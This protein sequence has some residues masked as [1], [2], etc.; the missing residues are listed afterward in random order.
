MKVPQ[1]KSGTMTFLGQNSGRCKI[2]VDKQMF[3]RKEF[4][5]SWL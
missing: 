4:Q 3:K 2:D 5:V 1:E